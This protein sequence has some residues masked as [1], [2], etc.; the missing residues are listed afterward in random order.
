M[1]C[2]AAIERVMNDIYEVTEGYTKPA[3]IIKHDLSCFFP[4]AQL[5]YMERCFVNIIEKN[6]A[7]IDAQHGDG[8]ADY[9]RWL[10]MVTI[11]CR[12]AEHCEF[13][14]PRWMWDEYITPEKSLIGKPPG[15]GA[16]IGRLP[17]QKGMGLYVNDEV[18]WFNDDCGI[19]TTCFMD[20]FVQV[21]PEWQHE[22]ALS[23][24]A[25]FDARLKAKGVKL[26]RKKFYDQPA[27]RGLEFLGSHIRNNRLHLNNATFNRAIERIRWFNQQGCKVALID[28]FLSSINSYTGLLKQRTDHDRLMR[29][30]DIVDASWW[31]FVHYDAKRQCL[32]ANEGYTHKEILYRKYFLTPKNT[33][34][35]EKTR[36]AR[37][38]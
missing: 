12:P 15:I 11:H 20:D 16:P 19:R 38:A 8:Y 35:N 18:R 4:N 32:V 36:T 26:N 6:R 17:S 33:K 7:E 34:P 28:R 3:R 31:E 30:I 27:Q 2:Q 13:R 22:Y 9:L 24:I 21:V 10:A 23:L 5:D 25:P 14:T 37:A 29:L 1:G